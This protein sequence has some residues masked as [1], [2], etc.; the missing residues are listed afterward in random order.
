MQICFGLISTDCLLPITLFTLYQ[1]SRG[2][3]RHK[4]PRTE[5]DPEAVLLKSGLDASTAAAFLQENM[6]EFVDAEAMDEAAQACSY[7][8]HTGDRNLNGVLCI[9]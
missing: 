8:S 3:C 1:S 2:V 4:R 6:L 5:V 9:P 7:L